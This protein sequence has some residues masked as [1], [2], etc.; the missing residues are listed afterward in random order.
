M[1]VFNTRGWAL[2]LLQFHKFL[3]P[4]CGFEPEVLNSRCVWHFSG[5][6]TVVFDSAVNIRS[7]WYKKDYPIRDTIQILSGY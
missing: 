3:L 5:I 1:I 4:S 7:L 6:S 2:K